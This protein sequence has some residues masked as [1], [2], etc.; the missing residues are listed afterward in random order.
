MDENVVGQ[1]VVRRREGGEK[2][3]AR[4]RIC[5]RTCSKLNLEHPLYNHP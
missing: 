1:L 5:N 3:K 2:D 4:G